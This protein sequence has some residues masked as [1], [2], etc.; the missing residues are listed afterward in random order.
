MQK[1]CTRRNVRYPDDSESEG[2]LQAY[3]AWYVNVLHNRTCIRKPFPL[4]YENLQPA[5]E[6]SKS[7]VKIGVRK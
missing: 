6:G 2:A 4:A 3:A 7:S 5:K 1:F